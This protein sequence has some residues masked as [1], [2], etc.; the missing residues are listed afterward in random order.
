M[1]QIKPTLVPVVFYI[2]ALHELESSIKWAVMCTLDY[3]LVN[4]LSDQL[5]MN[6]NY[7]VWDFMYNTGN[8]NE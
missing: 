4:P 7:V 3:R 5:E 1:A 8:V 2:D 6:L